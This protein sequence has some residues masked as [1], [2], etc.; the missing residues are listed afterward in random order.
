VTLAGPRPDLR[1]RLREYDAVL[2][3]SRVEGLPVL[4]IEAQCAQVPVLATD[5]PGLAESL[6]PSYPGR[7]PRGDPAA[8]AAMISEF[9]GDPDRW[10]S[11]TSEA[12]AWADERF[13]ARRMVSG[14]VEVYRTL[15]GARVT[16]P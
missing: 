8:F 9:V 11:R 2:L 16:T 7:C 6:P 15:L 1:E 12:R 13:S 3:P 4:A 5:A 14:Y 10:R